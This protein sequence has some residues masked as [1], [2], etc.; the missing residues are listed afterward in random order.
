ML[1]FRFE[2][3]LKKYYLWFVSEAFVEEFVLFSSFLFPWEKKT[4]DIKGLS[5]LSAE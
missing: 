4:T 1:S 2:K 3:D 5:G